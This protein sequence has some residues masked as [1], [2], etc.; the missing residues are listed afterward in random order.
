M[1]AVKFFG[2][3]HLQFNNVVAA[4]SGRGLIDLPAIKG[5]SSSIVVVWRPGGMCKQFIEPSNAGLHVIDRV[6]FDLER[7]DWAQLRV[8]QLL[9]TDGVPTLSDIDDSRQVDANP[10]SGEHHFEGRLS[11]SP[12][13]SH[14]TE[15][16]D[17]SLSSV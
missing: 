2:E 12:E 4:R 15:P 7:A 6:G 1:S 9:M 16:S 8:L 10:A 13:G 17:D 14:E 5:Y 3:D 11:T